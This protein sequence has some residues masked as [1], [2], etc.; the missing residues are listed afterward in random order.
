MKIK[1]IILENFLTYE[2]LEYDFTDKAVLVQGI[3]LTDKNQKS[4]GSGKSA[5]QTGI[6]FAIT[7]SN[8]RGVNDAE[9]VTYGFK[10]AKVEL[11]I[12]CESRKEELHIKWTISVKGSNVLSLSVNGKSLSFSNVNDGKKMILDWLQISKEDLFNYFIINST[13]FKSFFGSSNREKVDLINRFSDSSI[14]DGLENIDNTELES[15]KRGVELS[16]NKLDGKKEL[17]EDQLLK[18]KNKDFGAEVQDKKDA[19]DDQIYGEEKAIKRYGVTIDQNEKDIVECGEESIKISTRIAEIKKEEAV[20]EQQIFEQSIVCA[21][22]KVIYDTNFIEVGNFKEKDF[23]S[24]RGEVK[25]S[26]SDIKAEIKQHSDSVSKVNKLVESIDVKLSGSIDCPK[27]DHEFT[28]EGDIDELKEKKIK[29]EIILGKYSDKIITL[30]KSRASIEDKLDAINVEEQSEITLRRVQEQGLSE[31][32][33]VLNNSLDKLSD[34]RGKLTKASS[35]AS[36]EKINISELESEIKIIRLDIRGLENQIKTSKERIK[37]LEAKRDDLSES[38]N[39]AVILGISNDIKDIG[40]SRKTLEANLFNVDDKIYNRNKWS[41]SF[42]Q[43]RMHLANKSLETMQ[44]MT[45]K[46]LSELGNDI[47]VR[48]DGYKVKANGSIKEEINALIIRDGERSFSSLSGGEQVR[49]LF[50]SVLAN[51]YLI[52]N[53]HPYG[54]LDFLSVDEVFDKVDSLGM[55]HLIRSASKL[56]TCIM[57]ISHVSDEDLSGEEILTIVKENGISTIKK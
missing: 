33:K 54:G 19:I 2:E 32:R 28:L 21:S 31:V 55:K 9:L 36:T 45:N 6:E 56:E 7:S 30:E 48:F 11:F 4:N 40:V 29:A 16:I 23:T 53:T 1:K 35:T 46:F 20:I 22:D 34:L 27:C 51:R 37:E 41:N 12:S 3:N 43:F 17:L 24:I 47:S 18:E 5:I 38:N 39:K 49:V 57:I 52:N 14:I 50:S 26:L 25:Q 8:S 42:K 10:E 13:R 15:E 44:F